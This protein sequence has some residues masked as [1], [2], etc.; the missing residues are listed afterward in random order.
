MVVDNTKMIQ[1]AIFL[2]S[3]S[4][5]KNSSTFITMIMATILE[6]YNKEGS[7]RKLFAAF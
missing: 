1:L 5:V 3:E 2:V 7:K 6:N 4:S